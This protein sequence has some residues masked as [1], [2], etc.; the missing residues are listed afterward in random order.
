VDSVFRA[1]V[2]EHAVELRLDEVSALRS[3][4]RSEGFSLLFRGPAA[5]ALEQAEY[6]FEHDVMGTFTLFI[7]PIAADDGGRYYEAIFN[8]LRV[9][10]S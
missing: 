7:V 9:A 6:R 4:P 1:L 8:R 3:T 5:V 10:P 2:G